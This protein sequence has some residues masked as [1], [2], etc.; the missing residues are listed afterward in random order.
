MFTGN[1][2]EAMSFYV[3]LFADGKIVAVDRY[4]AEQAASAGKIKQASF[5]IAGQ[6]FRCMDSPVEHDFSFTPSISIFVEC[7]SDKQITELAEAFGRDGTAFMPLGAYIFARQFAWI[8]DRF[9]V[10]WQL[11]LT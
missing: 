9:G 1:A 10:C 7:S 8:Q 5:T 2:E 4:G 6:T 3:S 11:S